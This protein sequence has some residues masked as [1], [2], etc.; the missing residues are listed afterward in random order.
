MVVT[1]KTEKQVYVS[2]KENLAEVPNW[3]EMMT[4]TQLG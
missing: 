4:T 3:I 2:Q 1:H